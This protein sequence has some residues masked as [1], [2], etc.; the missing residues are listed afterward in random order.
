GHWAHVRPWGWTWVDDAPWGLAPFHYGRWVYHRNT[1]CWT[2]GTRVARPVYAPA[3]VGWVGGARGSVSVGI[4]VGPAV[5]WFP[6]GPRE[7]YVPSYRVSSRYARNL[8][9]TN[10]NA[11]IITNVFRNPQGPREFENRRHPRAITVVPASV[12][13]ERRPVGPAAAQY[14]QAPWVR[15]IASDRGRAPALLAPQIA[16]P[17]TPARSADTRG[18][19][20]PPGARPDARERAPGLAERPG[21][22]PRD[23]NDANR[24]RERGRDGRPQPGRDRDREPERGGFTPGQR[25][26]GLPQQPNVVESTRPA[27][28]NRGAPGFGRPAPAVVPTAP[29]AA[30]IAPVANPP[31]AV[32]PPVPIRQPFE[33]GRRFG[34]RD[35]RDQRDPSETPGANPRAPVAPVMPP[36]VQPASPPVVVPPPAPPQ[37]RPT[38]RALPVQRGDERGDGRGD[39]RRGDER[40]MDDRRPQ[41]P[42]MPQVPPPQPQVMQAPRVERPAPP[43]R[44]VDVP[45]PAA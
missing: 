4:G 39:G 27:E 22:S 33:P 25:P 42:E 29:P 44:P 36:A 38:M 18:V 32:Q 15:D 35:P 2:P 1:W 5:G 31:T 3:L 45:R 6:L 14:R 10:V 9:I 21:T 20:P 13:A 28:A 37:E 8:N 19:R 7:V 43:P 30:P 12:M 40:R 41:R 24:E 34:N 26:P 23:R 17:P 11:T 16:T